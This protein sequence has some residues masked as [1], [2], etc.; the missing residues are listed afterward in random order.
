MHLSPLGGTI[1]LAKVKSLHATPISLNEELL[2]Y[3]ELYDCCLTSE[4]VVAELLCENK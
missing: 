3:G 1:L 4:A 2:I